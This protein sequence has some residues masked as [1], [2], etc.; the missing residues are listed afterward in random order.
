MGGCQLVNKQFSAARR[1][2]SSPKVDRLCRF[3]SRFEWRPPRPVVEEH[4]GGSCGERSEEIFKSMFPPHPVPWPPSHHH[5]PNQTP[6]QGDP[7]YLLDQ[8]LQDRPSAV[9]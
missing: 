5:H 1:S 3:P 6:F 9:R 2:D 4:A 7:S 8:I